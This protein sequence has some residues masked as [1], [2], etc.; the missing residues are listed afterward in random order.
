MYLINQLRTKEFHWRLARFKYIQKQRLQTISNCPTK[1]PLHVVYLLGHVSVCGGVKVLFEHANELVKQGLRVSLLSHFPQPDWFS[2]TADYLQVPFGIELARGIPHDTDVLVATYWDQL[3]A[4]VEACIAPVVYFEQGDFH[5][6]D[7]ATV[8]SAK[9]DLIYRL[10]QLPAHI[11]TCSETGAKKIQEIFH[12]E[13]LV[14]HNALNDQ[15]FFP[16]ESDSRDSYV[17]GVGSEHTAFKRIPDIWQACQ[18]VQN[19]GYNV[20]FKWITQHPPLNSMG[21]VVVNPSQPQL[22]EEYRQGRIYVC[23]SEYE[24]FPLPPLE[25]MACGTPVITTPNDGV[26]AYGLDG[27]NCLFFQTGNTTALAEKIILL[28]ENRELYQHLQQQG[29]QTAARF[30]WSLI[31]PQ[32]RNF[33]GKVALYEPV[34]INSPSDWVKLIPEEFSQKDQQTIDCLLRGTVADLIYLPFTYQIGEDLTVMRWYP[35]YQRIVAT[36]G[37]SDYLYCGFKTRSLENYPYREA[38]G[39]IL[40]EKYGEAI[41]KFKKHLDQTSQSR[42]AAVVLRWVIWCLL[43]DNRLSEAQT[44][45]QKGYQAYP[46]YTDIYYLYGLLFQQ[47]GSNEK[48][49]AINNTIKTLGDAV[50]FPE[51]I[52]TS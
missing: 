2:I 9:K 16:K 5:L 37:Q 38:V 34:A 11:I 40:V 45:L 24:T 49:R 19:K 23:A 35:A 33:Y 28:L 4:C 52:V 29:Y 17:L 10:Y 18:L 26:K 44:L 21:E 20:Q 36:S 12:R 15:I 42:E 48:L 30:K 51:F 13:A 46:S 43:K 22:G 1:Q 47:L 3:S 14:F 39:D 31:I 25:A 32:L 6:W 27:E 41:S 7:W 8:D 50:A